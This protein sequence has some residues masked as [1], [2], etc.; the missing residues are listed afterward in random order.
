MMQLS[1]LP[2]IP[3]LSARLALASLLILLSSEA[4]TAAS[5]K[6]PHEWVFI[7]YMS[8]DNDLSH[9]GPGII[10]ALKKGIVNRNT[11]VLV[12]ADFHGPGGMKRYAL[13]KNA[14]ATP[15]Q[16]LISKED[17]ADPA[18]LRSYLNWVAKEWP[19]KNY[20]LVF[21]NHGGALNQMCSDDNP[22][23][24]WSSLLPK[25]KWLDAMQAGKICSDFN[26]QVGGK[27]RLLYLQQCGRGSIENLYN[28]T[29]SARYIL[30]SP[31][32]VGAPNTYYTKVLSQTSSQP[33][34]DGFNLAR[35]IMKEDQHYTALT[36]IDAQQLQQLPQKLNQLIKDIKSFSLQ[37]IS[38]NLIQVFSAGSEIN[39]DA[40]S[41]IEGLRN[42]KYPAQNQA[43]D[44]FLN[45]Y[46]KQLIV[47]KSIRGTQPA[48]Q[49]LSGLSIHLPAKLAALKNYQQ[50][51]IYQ[52][53]QLD[54]LLTA[55]LNSLPAK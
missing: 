53:S 26:Q 38:Q 8:Y 3:A 28:F 23:T 13:T 55:I 35:M 9:L 51:P 19:A 30:S 54:E 21:L 12:Q 37:Q 25:T 33:N 32:P 16:L 41:F 14:V 50:L 22:G 7:Y 42:Q 27:V 18:A 49:R 2:K 47:D 24:A 4:T 46:T 45:W 40:S 1:S 20:A 31:L 34:L 39:F 6:K 17:S 44:R 10:K 5:A 15:T 43:I 52:D 36:L 29:G 11:A 48:L